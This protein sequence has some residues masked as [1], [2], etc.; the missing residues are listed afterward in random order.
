[1]HRAQHKQRRSYISQCIYAT[2][3]PAVPLPRSSRTRRG[4]RPESHL[5]AAWH[6]EQEP[7]GAHG[8]LGDQQRLWKFLADPHDLREKRRR[9]F[10][11]VDRLYRF[12]SI[13]YCVALIKP[14]RVGWLRYRHVDNSAAVMMFF[15]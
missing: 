3:V 8:G 15:P 11:A 13:T 5:C 1:M 9:I 12:T 7:L 10:I 14:Y 6:F 2:L 4:R